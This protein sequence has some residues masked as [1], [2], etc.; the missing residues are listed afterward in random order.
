M[1]VTLRNYPYNKDV[2]VFYDDCRAYVVNQKTDYEALAPLIPKE[3]EI[4]EPVVVWQY[5]NCR[6][7]DFMMNG[8]YRI[9]QASVQVRFQG[10]EDTVDGLY[11]L[12]I[13]EDDAVPVLGGREE[14]GMPKVV[15]GISIDRRFE[16]HCFASAQANCETIARMR[17][18]EGEEWTKEK[19]DEYNSHNMV[20]AFGNRCIP[21]VD[22]PGN[23]FSEYVLYP[24]QVIARRVFSGTGEIKVIAPDEWYVQPFFSS[25]LYTL[26]S[27]PNHGFE[28]A[29]SMEGALRLCVSDSKPL[30]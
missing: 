15:C 12:L 30:K 11:P 26:S 19:V 28:N 24:Q 17:Y 27:L 1:P 29:F 18:D 21:N 5:V 8:E 4:L 9:I 22:R 25:M 3:F 23:A 13:L 20:A 10:E 16:N 6:G 7:V 14:D 2:R